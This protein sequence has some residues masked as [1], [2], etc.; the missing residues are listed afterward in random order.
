MNPGMNPGHDEMSHEETRNHLLSHLDDICTYLSAGSH[1]N[2]RAANASRKLAVR[3]FGRWHDCAAKSNFCTL[4]CLEKIVGDKLGHMPKIDM[5]M[6]SKAEMYN[7]ANMNDFKAHFKMWMDMQHE[8]IECL[9]HAIH[10]SRTI[11]MQIYQK[12]CCMADEAQDEKMRIRMVHDNLDFGGW[13]GHDISVKSKWIHEYF[14]H[15]HKE[16]E[17]ININLG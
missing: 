11:D 5:Q 16:G 4:D 6:V 3:G 2:M 17:P 1:W 15:Q 8:L 13:N 12:L 9:N 14:E 10:K 7:M